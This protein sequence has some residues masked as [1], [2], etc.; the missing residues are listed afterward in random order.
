MIID[1]TDLYSLREAA[2]KTSYT[3]KTIRTY[4]SQN[5]VDAVRKNGEWFVTK[6]GLTALLR[7]QKSGEPDPNDD[8]KP[9]P[10]PSRLPVTQ[11]PEPPVPPDQDKT[12]RTCGP[13]GK[14]VHFISDDAVRIY[15][16]LAE[17]ARICQIPARVLAYKLISEG[18]DRIASDID[19]LQQ[20]EAKR[21]EIIQRL[22]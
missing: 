22:S 6:P 12:P 3:E 15:A 10:D 19:V 9:V 17:T 13:H 18:L 20:L 1:G 21:M 11:H 5:K 16:R 8:L 7:K 2:E 4:I 14:S